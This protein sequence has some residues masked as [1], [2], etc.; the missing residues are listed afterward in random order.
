M[1]GLD[2][3]T[4]WAGWPEPPG[5]SLPDEADQPSFHDLLARYV[6]RHACEVHAE[7]ASCPHLTPTWDDAAD[8]GLWAGFELE[9]IIRLSTP[10]ASN[11]RGD[12][13]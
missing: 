8:C 6:A 3:Q 10:P 2:G 12:A 13:P 9:E 5:Q 7:T 11:S 1:T 4:R